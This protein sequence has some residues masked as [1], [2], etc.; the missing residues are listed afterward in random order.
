[1]SSPDRAIDG[2]ERV[3]QDAMRERRTEH[4]G[5]VA[6]VKSRCDVPRRA[7]RVSMSPSSR[8]VPRCRAKHVRPLVRPAPSRRRWARLPTR[9]PVC[10]PGVRRLRAC[11]SRRSSASNLGPRRAVLGRIPAFGD[12]LDIESAGMRLETRSDLALPPEDRPAGITRAKHG[13]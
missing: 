9:D 12:P 11:G 4:R 6:S 1:L 3:V 7:L 8:A 13:R 5:G 2:V 10:V